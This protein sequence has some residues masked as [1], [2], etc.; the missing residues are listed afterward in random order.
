MSLNPAIDKR[1]T[2]RKLE[3]GRLNRA[4]RVR[5]APGGKAAHVA[6]V[7]QI[8]G[9]NVAWAGFHGGAEGAS[10]MEG[11]NELGIRTRGVSSSGHTRTNLEIL[12][13]DGT[14]TEL[15]E[16]GPMVTPTE[17][18]SL[19]KEC[20]GLLRETRQPGTMIL[21]GSLPPGVSVDCYKR[22]TELGHKHG[23]RVCAD[24]TGEPLRRA[25]EA[26]PDFVKVNLSE[27]LETTGIPIQN[28]HEVG[29]ALE[30]LVSNGAR[31][32]AISLGARGLAW[33]VDANSPA[34]YAAAPAVKVVSAVG[35]GD[36]A[37]AG[38]V[39]GLGLGIEKVATLQLAVAC[40]AANCLADLPGQPQKNEIERFKD[41]VD[42]VPLM[43]IKTGESL[44]SC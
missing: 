29:I 24:T 31:S 8:L 1:L 6:M 22:F 19:F 40:G 41:A 12:D 10:L 9:A 25:L 11:L 27:A 20:E 21:S 44:R 34:L 3:S 26:R 42:V 15:L 33:Q 7:L 30:N 28:L 17:I 4:L 35:S 32:A 13:E 38:F 23:W 18:V 36:A 43:S 2:V 14:V 5:A 37:L 39:F 16:P